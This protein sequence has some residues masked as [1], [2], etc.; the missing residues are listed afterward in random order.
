MRNFSYFVYFWTHGYPVET[1][2]VY[3][4]NILFSQTCQ[5][6]LEKQSNISQIMDF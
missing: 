6:N 1:L 3:H 4:N 2:Y 5:V